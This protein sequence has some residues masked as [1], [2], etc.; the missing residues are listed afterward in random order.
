MEKN[1]KILFVHNGIGLGGAPKALRYIIEACV[2]EGYACWVAC[3]EC[4][5]T[6]P[7]FKDAGADIIIL[8]SLPRYTNST[9][10]SYDVNSLEFKKEREYAE[11]YM[12][13]WLKL[14]SERDH[15]DIV[16][17]NSMSLCDLIMPS[18]LAG[19]KVIQ[20][21]RETARYGE[22]LVIMKEIISEADAIIF[23]SEYDQQLF[24]IS[25]NRTILIP[26][27]VDPSLYSCESVERILLREKNGISDDDV[28]LLFTGGDSFIKGG[29]FLLTSLMTLTG[30]QPLTLLYAGYRNCNNK[31]GIKS[32]GKIIISYFFKSQRF[33][34]E[35]IERLLSKLKKNKSINVKV[36]GYCQDISEYFKISDICLVPYIVPHQALPIIE[37][38]MSKIPCLVSDHSCF[39]DEIENG[40]NGYL[41]AVNDPNAWS[42]AVKDLANNKN[43]REEL[44]VNNYQKAILRHDFNKNAIKLLSL[45]D[46]VLSAI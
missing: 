1:N 7:Y 35:K 43:K 13:Y 12:A 40:I 27:A 8:D 5:Q 29:E 4:S 25:S 15:F 26:D 19:C 46:E 16:F 45:F 9:T 23:I 3:L 6:V 31:K 20:V 44:G 30:K 28:V 2:R 18:K 38:G 36:L 37:A 21:I 39:K 22:S 32:F 10:T 33:N 14:L 11:H 42:K 34:Q 17:I 24:S 41:L